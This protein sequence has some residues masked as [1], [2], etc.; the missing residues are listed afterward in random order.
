MPSQQTWTVAWDTSEIATSQTKALELS[1]EQLI[2]NK[3]CS[4]NKLFFKLDKYEEKANTKELL[5]NVI[6]FM[7]PS[8]SQT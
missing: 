7:L 1:F 6:Q 3:I 5:V 4:R 8:I 2:H